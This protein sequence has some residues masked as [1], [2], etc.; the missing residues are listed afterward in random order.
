MDAKYIQRLHE[1][2]SKIM[3]IEIDGTAEKS[4]EDDYKDVSVGGNNLHE[5]QPHSLEDCPRPC[6]K[7]HLFD[8]T[9]LTARV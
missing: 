2:H 9:C 6:A 7:P 8:R 3:A 5:C 4:K 1:V